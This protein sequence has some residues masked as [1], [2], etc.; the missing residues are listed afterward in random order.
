M[1][2]FIKDKMLDNSIRLTII[3]T[4]G[5]IIIVAACNYFITGARLDLATVDAVVEP[6][7]NGVW[8]Y[9]LHKLYKKYH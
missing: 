5:H 6:C 2:K 4:V 7:I 8:F 1:L 9:I 3:Y